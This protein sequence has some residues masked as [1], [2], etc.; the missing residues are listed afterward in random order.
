MTLVQSPVAYQCRCRVALAQVHL[1]LDG[2]PRQVG[3]EQRQL[4][5]GTSQ[6]FAKIDVT[7]RVGFLADYHV[8]HQRLLLVAAGTECRQRTQ[9]HVVRQCDIRPDILLQWQFGVIDLDNVGRVHDACRQIAVGI[10]IDAEG[11]GTVTV[12]QQ[13]SCRA[14]ALHPCAQRERCAAQCQLTL[15]CGGRRRCSVQSQCHVVGHRVGVQH[16]LYDEVVALVQALR[17][18]VLVEGHADV[19]ALVQHAVRRLRQLDGLR[20]CDVLHD[21]NRLAF[22]KH[23]LARDGAVGDGTE[24]VCGIRIEDAA[25]HVDERVYALVGQRTLGIARWRAL[26]PVVYG[27]P[28]R[29]TRLALLQAHTVQYRAV[30]VIVRG[31]QHQ[32][33]VGRCIHQRPRGLQRHRL[34]LRLE[35]GRQP[36]V[37]AQFRFSDRVERKVQTVNVYHVLAGRCHLQLHVVGITGA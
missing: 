16:A 17:P 32:R 34:W 13:C 14:A 15:R 30:R 23:P 11:I 25:V 24:L 2:G 5:H 31:R 18:D 29:G 20:Q 8:V 1:S 28:L 9:I 12:P 33:R 26:H 22:A 10:D 3:T 6:S 37:V 19:V 7:R 21:G 27:G 36:D 4:V 35:V